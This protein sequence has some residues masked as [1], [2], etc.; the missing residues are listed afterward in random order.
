M[1]NQPE[2]TSVLLEFGANP[3]LGNRTRMTP[4]QMA[5]IRDHC[6]VVKHLLIGGARPERH[7]KDL[8]PLHAAALNGCVQCVEQLVQSKAQLEG[9]DS[10]RKTALFCALADMPH[11]EH[12][13]R[14]NPLNSEFFFV[15]FF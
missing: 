1:H 9:E 11:V 10:Q 8:P 4:I 5:A 3:D 12:H 2:V 13:Y 15:V 6:Q 14:Y 7:S